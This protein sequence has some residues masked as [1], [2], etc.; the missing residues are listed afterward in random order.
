MPTYCYYCEVCDE[1]FEVVQSIKDESLEECPICK[2]NGKKPIPPK[3][4][5]SKTSFQLKGQCWA[6]DSYSK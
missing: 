6:K 3:R 2:E 5:I 4:L 1:E